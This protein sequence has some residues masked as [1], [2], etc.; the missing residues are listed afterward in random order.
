MSVQQ[1]KIITQK[2]VYR[3]ALLR[4]LPEIGMQGLV[5]HLVVSFVEQNV[6]KVTHHTR[7]TGEDRKQY[8]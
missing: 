7:G 8:E 3:A 6:R 4:I 2:A 5:E 1:K